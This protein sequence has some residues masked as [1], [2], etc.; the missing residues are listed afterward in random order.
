MIKFLTYQF[1]YLKIIFKKLFDLMFFKKP[2]IFIRQKQETIISQLMQLKTVSRKTFVL[3][4]SLN[5]R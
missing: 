2:P 4:E 1:Q 3:I 5:Q